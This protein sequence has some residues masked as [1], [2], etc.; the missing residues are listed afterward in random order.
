MSLVLLF[1]L[2]IGIA[3]GAGVFGMFMLCEGFM[4]P[5]ASIPTY[6]KFGYYLAFHS[7]SFESFVF[8]QFEMKHQMQLEAF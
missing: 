5:S 2:Y 8:K 4:I 3:L 6:W 7:Y 1:S